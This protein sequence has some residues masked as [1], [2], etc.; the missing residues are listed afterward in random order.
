M[1]VSVVRSSKSLRTEICYRG[2]EQTS[3]KPKGACHKFIVTGHAEG[4]AQQSVGRL[5]PGVGMC[6]AAGPV[7]VALVEDS[8]IVPDVV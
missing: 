4:D 3:E 2:H 5:M 7:A 1:P 8:E 6:Y